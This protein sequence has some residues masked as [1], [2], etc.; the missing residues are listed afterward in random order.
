[1]GV[2]VRYKKEESEIRMPGSVHA[3]TVAQDGGIMTGHPEGIQL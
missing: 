1:M 3:P 2:L